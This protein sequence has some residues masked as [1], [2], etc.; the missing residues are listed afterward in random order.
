MDSCFFSG[1][2]SDEIYED[3]PTCKGTGWIDHPTGAF[4]C[5]DCN[6]RGYVVVP[7]MIGKED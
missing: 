7:M 4:E 5:G 6:A 2:M 1:K 3:C